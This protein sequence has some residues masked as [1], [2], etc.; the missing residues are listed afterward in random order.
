[1]ADDFFT[2]SLRLKIVFTKITVA[3]VVKSLYDS[4]R[5]SS[6]NQSPFDRFHHPFQNQLSLVCFSLQT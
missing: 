1:M 2:C 4:F 3:N 6:I 5:S